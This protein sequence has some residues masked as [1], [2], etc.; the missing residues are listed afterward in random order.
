VSVAVV[1]LH[2]KII[3]VVHCSFWILYL[4][5]DHN[6]IFSSYAIYKYIMYRSPNVKCWWSGTV[7]EHVITTGGA[8][9]TVAWLRVRHVT[10]INL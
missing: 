7:D 1:N 4:S 2:I 8:C 10:Q 6:P 9:V 3:Y 5:I